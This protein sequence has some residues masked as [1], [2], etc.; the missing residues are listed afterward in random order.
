MLREELAVAPQSEI[1]ATAP[2]EQRWRLADSE[3]DQ[4]PMTGAVETAILPYVEVK[5]IAI[6]WYCHTII[7]PSV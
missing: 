2:Y 1:V 5:V 6:W 7:S 3:R 4:Y